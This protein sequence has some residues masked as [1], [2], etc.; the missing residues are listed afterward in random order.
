MK[1]W[2]SL[3]SVLAL[4]L[5]STFA[6]SVDAATAIEDH[7][8]DGVGASWT[9]ATPVNVDMGGGNYYRIWYPTN[10]GSGGY[11]HPVIGFGVGIGGN[12]PWYDYTCNKLASYGYVVIGSSVPDNYGYQIVSTIWYLYY[13]N[14]TP[15]STFYNKLDLDKIG[16]LG[17]SAGAGG[18]LNA[19][20]I[21]PFFFR[22]AILNAMPCSSVC[23]SAVPDAIPTPAEMQ[24]ITIPVWIQCGTK[25]SICWNTSINYWYNNISKAARAMAKQARHDEIQNTNNKYVGYIVAW[26]EYTLRGDTYAKGAFKVS[27]GQ[28]EI[29]TNTGKWQNWAAK[30]L[31]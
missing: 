25:D 15:G 24:T 31:P 10:L 1:K 26:F 30:N 28:P 5:V 18:A 4:L 7:Y 19:V 17:H 20:M 12:V 6:R 27:S 23:W 29:Q 9:P 21:S 2:L 13:Q 14:L 16:A 11:H 8:R 3:I 22:S